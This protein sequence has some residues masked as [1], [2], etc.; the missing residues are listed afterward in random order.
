MYLILL[1]GACL[2]ALFGGSMFVLIAV[3]AAPA[4]LLVV[5]RSGSATALAAFLAALTWSTLAV[6][7]AAPALG[8]PPIVPVLVASLIG[9][10]LCATRIRRRGISLRRNDCR[11]LVFAAVGGAIWCSVIMIAALLPNGTPVSWSMYG[12][13]ANNVMFARS[14]VEDGG[15]AFGPGQNPVPL[16]S[17]LIALFML[18][19]ATFGPGSVQTQIFALAQMWSFGIGTACVMCGA[20]LLSLA[21][22]NTTLAWIS[23]A[24]ASLLPLS[25]LMLA[26]SLELGFVN[27]HLTIAVVIASLV[28]LVPS[29]R[30]VTMRIVTLS[31]LLTSAMALW[32]PIASVP[33]AGLVVVLATDRRVVRTLRGLRLVLV[34]AAILQAVVFFVLLP[35]PSL[36]SQG[37]ALA[38]A[39]G[40]VLRFP[41]GL[42]VVVAVVAIVLGLSY[43]RA[44][45]SWNGI[46]VLIATLVGGSSGLAVLL[47]ARRNEDTI[48]SYY[49]L[50]MLWIMIAILFIIAVAFGLALAASMRGRSVMRAC[51]LLGTLLLVLGVGERSGAIERDYRL[52]VQMRSDPLTRVV[53]GNFFIDGEGDRVFDRVVDLADAESRTLL[54]GTGDPDE[55]AIMFWI[56]QMASSGVGGAE[57]RTHAYYRDLESIE[58]ACAI[59]ELMGP[60]VAVETRDPE[61]AKAFEDSC[62]DLGAVRLLE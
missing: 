57:L 39:T 12:D 18:P 62:G 25:W 58:Q 40:A 53:T 20:L 31:L 6:F 11:G 2:L 7:S 44:T 28:V 60:P 38:I 4:F 47:W 10:T 50:K 21:R 45:R 3:A 1:V 52:N 5:E 51:V 43:A 22:R 13:A 16:T 46:R 30:D 37:E 42:L 48:W 41:S 59:R 14:I 9:G 54:W 17:A 15:I 33:A 49:Q 19:T 55:A 23:V 8:V 29:G 24:L 27:L 35:L 32:S 26:G 56:I 34:C 61:I 36:L